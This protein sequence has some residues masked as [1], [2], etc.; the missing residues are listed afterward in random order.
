[1]GIILGDVVFDGFLG[2]D[3]VGCFDEDARCEVLFEQRYV[4]WCCVGG[5]EI[6]GGFDVIC[7]CFVDVGV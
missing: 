2:V 7:F 1:M 3:V 6:G 4:L 5:V